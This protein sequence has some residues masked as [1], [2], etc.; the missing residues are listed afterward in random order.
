MIDLCLTKINEHDLT[1]IPRIT[2]L[3]DCLFNE[4]NVSKRDER[5]ICFRRESE[6][7]NTFTKSV[8]EPNELICDEL[9]SNFLIQLMESAVN[10]YSADHSLCLLIELLLVTLKFN[11]K[12][13]LS[14]FLKCNQNE[15]VNTF[16]NKYIKVWL[17]NE[18]LS[19]PTQD[20]IQQ[21]RKLV[22]M[23]ITLCH[24]DGD[25]INKLSLLDQLAAIKDPYI[26][27]CL[28]MQINQSTDEVLKEWLRTDAA[29]I[30]IVNEAS[31]LIHQSINVSASSQRDLD[32][33]WKIVSHC[34]TSDLIRKD[35]MEEII[36]KFR[37]TIQNSSLK[38]ENL[39]EFTCKLA[40]HLF[41]GYER[42]TSLDSAKNLVITLFT[43][44]LQPTVKNEL[45][46]TTWK[47]AV[48]VIVKS[49]GA[50]LCEGGVISMLALKIRSRLQGQLKTIER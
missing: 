6:E 27:E 42:C 50:Y 7:T 48:D 1:A 39:I 18:R 3:V 21:V 24:I 20:K 4:P 38:T 14:S 8:K 26:F 32:I 25:K 19:L 40:S 44:S 36:E 17:E 16:W 31:H 46:R 45:L 13:T 49:N 29:G 2:L 41:S 30:S 43:M 22:E 37:L 28:L 15:C 10:L 33:L 9:A 47:N 11:T 34:F 23:V 35:Y 12:Q 5:K